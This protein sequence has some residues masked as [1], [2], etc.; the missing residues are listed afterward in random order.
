VWGGGGRV[1]DPRSI[2]SNFR[3]EKKGKGMSLGVR[4]ENRNPWLAPQEAFIYG[5]GVGGGGGGG[6]GGKAREHHA[7]KI[8]R[9]PKH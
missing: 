7:K 8:K 1:N 5:G 9:T 3:I 2:N 4:S 6:V